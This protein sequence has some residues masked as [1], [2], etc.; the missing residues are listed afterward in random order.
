[1]NEVKPP[2]KSMIYYYLIMI[3]VLLCINAW[4]VPALSGQKI[5]EVDYS[6]FL[7]MLNEK[8]IAQVEIQDN[9]IAIKKGTSKFM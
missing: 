1:M 2:K 8:S 4:I 9:Q 3:V 6:T 7:N 5:Q